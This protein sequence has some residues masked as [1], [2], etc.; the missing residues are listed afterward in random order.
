M[1]QNTIY[2]LAFSCW[3]KEKEDRPDVNHLLS[4]LGNFLRQ[5]IEFHGSV[6]VLG[7]GQRSGQSKKPPETGQRSAIDMTREKKTRSHQ[8]QQE[9]LPYPR[10]HSLAAHDF[11]PWQDRS[12]RDIGMECFQALERAKERDNR[13]GTRGGSIIRP[14]AAALV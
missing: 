6:R 13:H 11:P 9:P 4:T 2:D 10:S 1:L 5:E 8:A 7:D 14:S 3:L 12:M